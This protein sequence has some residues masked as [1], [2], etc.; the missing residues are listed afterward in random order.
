MLFNLSMKPLVHVK[1]LD[2]NVVVVVVIL[3]T[4]MCPWF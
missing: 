4:H 1:T 2:S 3:G